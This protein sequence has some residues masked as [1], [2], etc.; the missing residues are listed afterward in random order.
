MIWRICDFIG[1]NS[2]SCASPVTRPSEIHKETKRKRERH[3]DRE[4]KN[5]TERKKSLLKR[6]NQFKLCLDVLCF[7][8]LPLSISCLPSFRF[9]SNSVYTLTPSMSHATACALQWKWL[10]KYFT[11]AIDLIHFYLHFVDWSSTHDFL[12]N[13]LILIAVLCLGLYVHAPHKKLL[14][15][16]IRWQCTHQNISHSLSRSS[17]TTTTTTNN[18]ARTKTGKCKS[19]TENETENNLTKIKSVEWKLWCVWWAD[20]NLLC[21]CSVYTVH[22]HEEIRSDVSERNK[23]Q[24]FAGWRLRVKPASQ[25]VKSNSLSWNLSFVPL[26]RELISKCFCKIVLL[27]PY[28]FIRS[29]FISRLWWWIDNDEPDWQ[30][31]ARFLHLTIGTKH[32]IDVSELG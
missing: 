9:L 8:C 13:P 11:Y 32:Q 17:S 12:F 27:R 19:D 25:P 21:V 2:H 18:K 15:F 7:L 28:L 16:S 14:W 30:V 3:R 22:A 1:C 24:W 10:S 5:Q 26:F 6:W 29:L 20:T 23:A 4:N 31:Q